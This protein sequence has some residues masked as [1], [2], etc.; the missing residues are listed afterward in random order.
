MQFS[1]TL[2][3]GDRVIVELIDISLNSISGTYI[4]TGENETTVTINFLN[5]S[6]LNE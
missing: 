6:T 1:G 4:S 3:S 2:D 5:A